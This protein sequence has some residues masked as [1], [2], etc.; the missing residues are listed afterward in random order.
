MSTIT[1]DLLVIGAGPAGEAAAMKARKAGKSV[2]VVDERT[3]VGG[4][5]T[6]VGTIPSK[7][8]RHAVRYIMQY[9]TDTMFRDIGEPRW[10]S[11]R[12]IKRRA[13][14]STEIQVKM[15]TSLYGRNRIDLEFGKARFSDQNTEAC[16]T[17]L[18][19][20]AI[21]TV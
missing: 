21:T 2:L 6:H 1:Y 7:A 17:K 8:L 10:F 19:I 3:S 9:N 14:K 15:R 20:D 11:F 12:K 5:C 4:N 13:E 18:Q 16:F